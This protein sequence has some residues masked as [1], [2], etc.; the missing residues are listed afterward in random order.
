M[1]RLEGGDWVAREAV[2]DIKSG[3]ARFLLS[4]GDLVWWGKQGGKPHDNPYWK[5]VNEDVLKQLPRPDNEMLAAGLEGIEQNLDPA[6][7]H[8]VNMYELPEAELKRRGVKS[9]PRTLLEAVEAFAADPLPAATFGADLARSYAELK[10]RE[11]WSYHN[12]V[13]EWELDAYLTKF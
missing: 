10:E 6:E 12:T 2:K 9:L 7:P 1:F 5:L 8:D 13:S 3:Q 4:T 11:W